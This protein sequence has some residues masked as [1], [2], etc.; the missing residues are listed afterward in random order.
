[1]KTI[2]IVTFWDSN[3]NYGQLLQN[4]A[5]TFFLKKMNYEPFLIKSKVIKQRSITKKIKKLLSYF[6][7]PL[8]LK[9]AI[10]Y[11]IMKKNAAEANKSHPRGFDI[12]RKKYIPFTK[13]YTLQELYEEPPK[14]DV[15]ITG[16]DQVWATLSP[17][18]FLQFA[19][20][21]SKKIAYA[22]SMGG[23]QPYGKDLETFKSYISNFDM[24]SLREQQSVDYLASQRVTNIICLPD[25]TLLLS[26]ADYRHICNLKE[27][28]SKPYVFLYLLGNKLDFNIKQ[29]Y[30]YAMQKKLDV[31]YV[32]SQGRTDKFPKT[33]PTTEEWLELI[34]NAEIIVTN[35]FHGTVFSMIFKKKFISILLS[36]QYTNTN[37]RITNILYKYGLERHIYNGSLDSIDEYPNYH[38][39]DK[40]L[41]EEI[42]FVKQKMYN[43][44]EGP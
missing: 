4:F 29:I 14:F 5:L 32:A 21:S 18:F 23:F 10:E 19:P 27:K 8:R 39:F 28:K 26:A 15:F 12:F 44:I 24:V 17:V 25:P 1:M 16:S 7:S 41:Q 13:E 20:S 30:E 31:I 6:F 34:E 22:A 3:D 9:H 35:S 11:K 33:Y 36:G 37:N 40:K 42:D 2:G 43:T 38:I